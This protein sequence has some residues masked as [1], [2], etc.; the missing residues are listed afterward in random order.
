MVHS[1]ELLSPDPLGSTQE[2]LGTVSPLRQ[3]PKKRGATPKKSLANTGSK[4]RLQ[5]F[6][7]T[8]P[9]SQRTGN[10]SPF[11]LIAEADN[12]AS[13]WRIRVTVE[14]EQEHTQSRDAQSPRN[15]LPVKRLAERMTTTTVP[16]ND[17]DEKSPAVPKKC[18]GRPRKSI[19]SPAKKIGTPKQKTARSRKTVPSS[20]KKSSNETGRHTPTPSKRRRGRP[21]K[22]A[23]GLA[24]DLSL[25]DAEGDRL[26][27]MNG[28]DQPR[29][30][31]MARTTRPRSQRPSKTILPTKSVLR[32]ESTGRQG[33]ERVHEEEELHLDSSAMA[34]STDELG[35]HSCLT[36]PTDEHGEFDSILESEGFS[37]V[38]VSSLPSAKLHSSSPLEPDIDDEDENTL[39]LD[40]CASLNPVPQSTS[41]AKSPVLSVKDSPEESHDTF[42]QEISSLPSTS[43]PSLQFPELEFGRTPSSKS[44]KTA[45]PPVVK[46]SITQKSPRALNKASDGTPKLVRVV[47][48]GVALQGVLSPQ[49][50]CTRSENTAQKGTSSLVLSAKS[51][52]E[53]LD[54]LFSGFGAGTRRELRAGLRLGEELAK[55]HQIASQAIAECK[56]EDEAFGREE[57]S[58]SSKLPILTEDVGYSLKL[59]ESSQKPLYP[60]ISNTQLPSPARSEDDSDDDRMSWKIDTPNEVQAAIVKAEPQTRDNRL[61]VR[62]CDGFE[63]STI[64]REEEQY[65]LE[66][67]GVIRQIKAANSSQVV[68]VN[69]DSEDEY[70]NDE[71]DDIWQ[72]QAH[73]SGIVTS[74]VFSVPSVLLRNHEPQPRRSQLPSSW[75]RQSEVSSASH[76]PANDSDSFW[77]PSRFSDVT[78]RS[79][80]LAEERNGED[81]NSQDS[82]NTAHHQDDRVSHNDST[83]EPESVLHISPIKQ[84]IHFMQNISSVTKHETRSL[85]VPYDEKLDQTWKRSSGETVESETQV[86]KD[87]TEETAPSVSQVAQKASVGEEMMEVPSIELR[88]TVSFV[89]HQFLQVSTSTSWF[90][91]LAS[92]V[93]GW[94]EATPVMPHRLPNG[95]RKLPRTGSLEG[96]LSLCMPWTTAHYNALY[97]HYSASKEGRKRYVFNAKS[98]SARYLFRIVRYRGWEKPVTKEDLAIVDAFMVDLKARGTSENTQGEWMIDEEVAVYKLFTLWHGGVQRGECEVGIGKIGLA[99]GS[100]EM[101]RPD[102]ESWCHEK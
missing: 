80:Q 16:L 28:V 96:P 88:E 45:L 97:F 32:F 72:E 36:D 25:R 20:T 10:A 94:G 15:I 101:W 23:E 95:K 91:Y 27:D 51:P 74:P 52:K 12:P 13:P 6:H 63:G 76:V 58:S 102:M 68:I 65:R 82:P 48:A 47:R 2:T 93:P 90:G 69:S 57:M 53:R 83:F 70:E 34:D 5:D 22:S 71:E 14:A 40:D 46:S 85:S 30:L 81:L 99:E 44:P 59:P 7:L 41:R 66:R 87:L 78:G 98:A 18:R 55:R 79:E 9:P 39:S 73:S 75:R 29:S 86:T 21:R 1:S 54:D 42:A 24:E 64:A 84:N 60:T 56:P 100:E 11:K 26:V 4:A 77:Q 17:A 49:N 38:S 37:M 43:A 92:F 8:T 62:A 31:N 3:S 19:D 89:P 35:S 33:S 50:V 67:E 61:G